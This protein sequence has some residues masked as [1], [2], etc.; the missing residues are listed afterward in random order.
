MIET[1]KIYNESCLE[2]MARMPDNYLDCVVTS[3]P[4]YGLRSYNTDPQ[5]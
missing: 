3:P 5:V 1:G 2:T 4:Y